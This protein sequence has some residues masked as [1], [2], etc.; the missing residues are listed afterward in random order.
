V[1][2]ELSELSDGI[3]L[4]DVTVHL[5]FISNV[6]GVNLGKA[7]LTSEVSAQVLFKV[8]NNFNSITVVLEGL[9]EEGISIA[10]VF[11]EL[12]SSSFNFLKSVFSPSLP[13]F[14]VEDLFLNVFNVSLGSLP[15]VLVDV[16]NEGQV[17]NG[18]STNS[19]VGLVLS[20]SSNLGFKVFSLKIS[21]EI[22]N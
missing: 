16:G 10:S 22:V 4:E 13:G 1:G 12:F 6:L 21:E 15:V 20:I 14:N 5:E 18:L 9:N 2:S 19:F 3:L 8:S 7:W 17:T 11:R